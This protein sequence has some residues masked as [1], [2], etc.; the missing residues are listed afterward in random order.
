[1]PVKL[2]AFD[3]DGTLFDDRKRLSEENLAALKAAQR[4]GIELVPATGRILH[5][6]P[7]ALLEPNLFRYF[8]FANGATVY[9]L[10]T[11]T[12]IAGA[13]IAPETAVRICEYLDALPVLYDC[14]RGEW[15]YMTQWM[16]DTAPEF[17]TLEPEILKLVKNLRKPVPELKDNIKTVNIPL[18]K[19]QVY[20]RPEQGKERMRLLS[21]LPKRFSEIVATSSLKNNIEI[22]SAEAGKGRALRELCAQLGIDPADAV[23]FGDGLNDADMLEAA[24]RG[25]AM[26]NAVE[27]VKQIADAVTE[28]N[29]D[30]GVGKE[31]FRLL[32]AERQ[33]D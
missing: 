9:D 29:N 6:L 21:E 16:Y 3:L 12:Q 22:N 32:A 28:N 15:G 14:Y 18:E 31:I 10:E 17:F 27:A 30:A 1:M 25:V 4:A 5:G 11:E 26:E 13:C 7:E 8:I 20:F 24:G 33:A 19:L 2:I 23:A